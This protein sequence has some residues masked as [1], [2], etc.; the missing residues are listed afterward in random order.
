MPKQYP[1]LDE[2]RALCEAGY[3]LIAGLDEAGRGAWAGPV[4]AAA[5]ILPLDDP[6][7][8]EKLTGVCDSKLCTPRQREALYDV[9][10]E[11]ALTWGVALVPATRI[12]EIGIVAA[13]RQAM[14][15]ALA[16]LDLRPAA[17][18]IDYLRLPAL[19]LPQRAIKKGDLKSL[20]IAAASIVAK[21]ARDREMCRLD[22][23]YPGYGL[24]RHKGYGTTAHR[25]ALQQLGPASIHRRSFAP[26]AA[27][28]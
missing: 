24:A 14:G 2:E 23:L 15:E 10:C 27:M 21:V 3:A 25:A 11:T 1:T 26:I 5:V 9:I 6:S 28:G 20:S 22:A 19:N 13:T 17:L 16:Q 18:L 7:L 4:S 8:C 12:D